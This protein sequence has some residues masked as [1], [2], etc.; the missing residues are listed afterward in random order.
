MGYVC[1]DW[2]LRSD[3]PFFATAPVNTPGENGPGLESLRFEVE[4]DK[5]EEYYT[6]DGGMDEEMMDLDSSNSSD[7]EDALDE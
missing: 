2:Q 7:Y 3:H 6:S 4:E 5:E 1:Q